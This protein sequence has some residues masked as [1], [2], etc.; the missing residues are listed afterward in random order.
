MN[1][2]VIILGSSR[3]N[4]N[5]RKVVDFI[6]ARKACEVIDLNDLKMGYYSYEFIH[7]NDDFI[8]TA[9]HIVENFD[10]I[11]FATPVYWYNMSAVMKTFFDRISDLLRNEEIVIGRKF[12]GM[13]MVV[14]SCSGE[15]LVDGFYMPFKESANYLG[16]N[17]LGQ[18]HTWMGAD[19]EVAEKCV[20]GIDGLLEKVGL[21]DK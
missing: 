15:D 5:T 17:Y 8:P 11:I 16:M 13:N 4:G 9:K 14:V 20:S 21:N 6:T 7:K 19:G 3:S 1:K 2:T 10:T 12:R 18:V